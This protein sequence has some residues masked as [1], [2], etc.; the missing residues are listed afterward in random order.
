MH[1][2]LSK[3]KQNVSARVSTRQ[4]AQTTQ[5]SNQHVI[6]QCAWQRDDRDHGWVYVVSEQRRSKPT[7]ANISTVSWRCH[8]ATFAPHSLD[9][10]DSR[11][12]T[13]RP[14]PLQHTQTDCQHTA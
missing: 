8:A 9:T 3:Q 12:F 2:A 5:R 11:Q 13:Y 14:V 10:A 4:Q 7:A 1:S 6:S